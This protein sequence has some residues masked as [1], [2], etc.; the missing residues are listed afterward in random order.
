MF[1]APAREAYSIYFSKPADGTYGW[2]GADYGVWGKGVIKAID[3]QTGKVRWTHEIG[4][5]SSTGV[6]TT[7]SRRHVE[8]K[9]RGVRVVDEVIAEPLGLPRPRRLGCEASQ[10]ALEHG[11]G[12]CV[13]RGLVIGMPVLPVRHRHSTRAG[14]A[15]EPHHV[16]DLLIVAGDSA[17]GPLQV[18]PPGRAEHAAR[19]FSFP[20]ALLGRAIGAELATGEVAESDPKSERR[21]DRDCSAET[22][23]EI[24]RMGPNT[25]RSTGVASECRT[26]R[27]QSL[28]RGVSLPLAPP[29]H[30]SSDSSSARDA[31]MARAV[32]D[33]AGP[34]ASCAPRRSAGRSESGERGLVVLDWTAQHRDGDLPQH[35]GAR[36][37]GRNRIPRR[38]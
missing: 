28:V 5:S 18:Q 37:G 21:V 24:V 2:A 3:Y 14:R 19:G 23:L 25:S 20:F 10:T 32:S 36:L 22:D 26:R 34:P 30:A 9:G 1:I 12:Q 35:A 7:A 13:A 15:D 11:P 33:G 4:D 16:E 38:T 8:N 29:S 17:V 31:L 27:L 6:M